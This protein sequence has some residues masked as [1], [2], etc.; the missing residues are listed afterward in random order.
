[1]HRLFTG[2][3]K[4]TNKITYHEHGADTGSVKIFDIVAAETQYQHHVPSSNCP[5]S[6]SSSDL[7]AAWT[8]G[9]SA[10]IQHTSQCRNYLPQ[11]HTHR[12]DAGT[13]Y[14]N[15]THVDRGLQQHKSSKD[16]LFFVDKIFSFKKWNF[17][18]ERCLSS[19]ST[20]LMKYYTWLLSALS[21]ESEISPAW[22]PGFV[23]YKY[24]H[25]YHLGL[26][27]TVS[28]QVIRCGLYLIWGRDILK[29]TYLLTIMQMN[30]SLWNN[31][32]NENK[33]FPI[34]YKIIRYLYVSLFYHCSIM[35]SF[36]DIRTC[37]HN[38][39]TYYLRGKCPVIPHRRS[40]ATQI[41][42]MPNNLMD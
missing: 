22:Q 35:M 33:W 6:P 23:L 4:S 25:R 37:T 24:S 21:G 29:M 16:I 12:K 42:T 2:S 18:W 19:T 1:M 7:H 41:N 5:T 26:A 39:T 31:Y 20:L 9:L 32:F 30:V 27:C 40:W 28:S 38:L 17:L 8:P 11:H 36:L 13:I 34:K 3:M 15:T 10:T 14:H